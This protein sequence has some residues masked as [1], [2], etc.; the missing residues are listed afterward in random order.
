MS[1]NKVEATFHTGCNHTQVE[2]NPIAVL[3][4]EVRGKCV[5]CGGPV[6]F[7]IAYDK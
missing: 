2:W 6:I 7:T 1:D 5:D 4:G 3:A